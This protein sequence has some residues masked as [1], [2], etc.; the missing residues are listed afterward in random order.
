MV[1]TIKVDLESRSYDIVIGHNILENL[2]AKI[3]QLA[4][5]SKI[6]VITDENVAKFHLDN[7]SRTLGKAGL[8]HHVLTLNPGE[9]TKDFNNL[10]DLCEKILEIGADRKTLLIAFGGGVI[11]DL[12]GFVAS[13][14]LRGVDFIQIPTTLL[15]AV[16]SSVGGKTAI[17]SKHGKNLIGSFYQPRLVFCD[18]QFLDSLPKR[19]FLSGYAEVIKYGL[20]CDGKFFEFLKNNS[21]RILNKDAEALK[22]IIAKSCEIKAEVVSKDEKESN[23]RAILNF[24][25]TFGHVFEAEINYSDELHHGEAV[26]LGMALAAKMSVKLGFLKSSQAEEIINY[27]KSVELPTSPKDIRSNWDEKHLIEH[28]YKDKKVENKHLTFILLDDIGSC[29]IKKDVSENSFIGTI[30]EF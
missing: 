25:H 2:P 27:L 29:L 13:I 20:I 26:A 8:K 16:D 14:L 5:Y 30:N 24:G 18:L 22:Y 15:A 12:C 9:K 4:T 7:F 11:G 10:E 19:E 17:N 6:F 21:G 23:L 3:N 1:K 28:L